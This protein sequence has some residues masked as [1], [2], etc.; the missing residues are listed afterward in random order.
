MIAAE[1]PFVAV[2][3]HRVVRRPAAVRKTRVRRPVAVLHAAVAVVRADKKN[4]AVS[5]E[6]RHN[7]EKLS[8][9]MQK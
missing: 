7:F 9:F 4:E 3:A 6:R 8:K 5:R 2:A 1:A